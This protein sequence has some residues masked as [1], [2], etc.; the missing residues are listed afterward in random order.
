MVTIKKH[1]WKYIFYS[2]II[3][4]ITVAQEYAN[5]IEFVINSNTYFWFTYFLKIY[6]YTL[7]QNILRSTNFGPP[8]QAH[9][10][11]ILYLYLYLFCICVV[12]S[13]NNGLVFITNCRK[14]R[15]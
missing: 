2:N 12:T 14:L 1:L 4:Y 10:Y 13:C 3:K 15:W 6:H 7:F 5:S 9:M 8:S 11:N